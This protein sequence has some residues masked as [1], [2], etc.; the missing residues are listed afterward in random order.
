[1][2]RI[3]LLSEATVNRIAAGEVIERPAAAVKELV[4]NALDAGAAPHRRR[5]RRRRH[6]PHRGDR[7]RQRHD[8]R[9][10]WRWRCSATPPRSSPTT[11][12]CASP[13]S[14]SAARRCPASAPPR[15]CHHLPPARRGA[16]REHR[17]EGGAGRRAWRPPP[18]RPARAWWCATCS[19]PPPPG[20]SSSSIPA[21]RP[22]HA[23][24]AVRR[25]ALAAPGV[26]FRLESDGRVA[27]DLPAQDRAA[28]VAALFGAGG[29]RRA[30]AGR[31]RARPAAPRRLRLLRRP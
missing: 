25:L 27:F 2:P 12:W 7:R 14:A 28:R 29:G 10:N 6:R 1:M 3:R 8:R 30:G 20:A 11:T 13:R 23:E 15:G 18:V 4:E 9:R 26:A 5:H 17:V 21:P 22:T 19:S 24:A 16:C 31:R